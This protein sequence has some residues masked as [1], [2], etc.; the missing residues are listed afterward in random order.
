MDVQLVQ[1]VQNLHE[2]KNTPTQEGYE[3]LEIDEDDCQGGVV[4]ASGSASTTAIS[5]Q[6]AYN[7]QTK[8]I[9]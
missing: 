8:E 6:T 2:K 4:R 7:L 1:N 5:I 3:G 9:A